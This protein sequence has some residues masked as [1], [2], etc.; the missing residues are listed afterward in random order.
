MPRSGIDCPGNSNKNTSTLCRRRSRLHQITARNTLSV[1]GVVLD[2]AKGDHGVVNLDELT[3]RRARQ[4]EIDFLETNVIAEWEM[5]FEG[6]GRR[7]STALVASAHVPV[8]CQHDDVDCEAV[9]CLDWVEVVCYWQTGC[10]DGFWGGDV[11]EGDGCSTERVLAL[12]ISGRKGY[13]VLQIQIA[14][15]DGDC[16]VGVVHHVC[17]WNTVF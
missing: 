4:A 7:V 1:T 6:L 2:R 14:G 13:L 16:D 12:S 15:S 5:D 17:G 11:Q 9:W 10:G 8:A 3:H